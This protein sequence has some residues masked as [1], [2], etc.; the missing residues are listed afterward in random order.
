MRLLRRIAYLSCAA[1]CL[2]VLGCGERRESSKTLS[3]QEQRRGVELATKLGLKPDGGKSAATAPILRP[4]KVLCKSSIAMRPLVSPDGR[5]V[6]LGPDLLSIPD[7]KKRPLLSG[8]KAGKGLCNAASWSPDGSRIV[9]SVRTDR[10]VTGMCGSVIYAYDLRVA[11]VA[12]GS[13]VLVGSGRIYGWS[14]DGKK[15][16]WMAF[17][18][19]E[20][21]V[22]SDCKTGKELSRKS[23]AAELRDRSRSSPP[24]EN[25]PERPETWLTEQ[26]NMFGDGTRTSPDCKM[27]VEV[28]F[29]RRSHPYR[30]LGAYGRSGIRE[31]ALLPM[32]SRGASSEET[33]WY[34]DSRKFLYF[35][36]P[37]GYAS[38]SRPQE[39][40]LINTKGK[41][42]S[43]Q[44]IH[45]NEEHSQFRFLQWLD[46]D[47][48]LLLYSYVSDD[49]KQQE[50]WIGQLKGVK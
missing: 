48:N 31:I 40:Y 27:V 2:V 44:L 18:G 23:V 9:V 34:P 4:V 38:P 22:V 19:H 32:Y 16:A 47:Q 11:T 39:L 46:A 37:A 1:L 35:T 29:P 42:T 20:Q 14:P 49:P 12:D 28:S 41:A 10:F 50:L 43:V 21:F 45:G 36:G 15:I 5:Y 17:P 7:G 30:F 24:A 8:S 33:L 13:S 3:V 25:D 26:Q 6:A